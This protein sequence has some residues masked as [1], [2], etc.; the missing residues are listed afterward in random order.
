M[1]ISLIYSFF[2]LLLLQSLLLW[3]FPLPPWPIVYGIRIRI[4]GSSMMKKN[5]RRRLLMQFVNLEHPHSSVQWKWEM[6]TLFLPYRRRQKKPIR[7]LSRFNFK[8]E[9]EILC[10]E[11]KRI[12]V[13]RHRNWLE[14]CPE[15][16]CSIKQH[17]S[18]KN[19]LNTIYIIL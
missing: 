12:Q 3:M 18:F 6:E 11:Y 16:G 15:S 13:L 19:N 7:S 9:E 5:S 8:S 10:E 1:Y 14:D 2:L 4:D 17:G